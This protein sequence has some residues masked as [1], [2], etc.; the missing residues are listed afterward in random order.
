MWG[1]CKGI[2]VTPP[3]S[4]GDWQQYFI[5]VTCVKTQEIEEQL[6]KLGLKKEENYILA[7]EYFAY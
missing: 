7:K 4:I 6:S 3:E 1:G 5:V 2:R